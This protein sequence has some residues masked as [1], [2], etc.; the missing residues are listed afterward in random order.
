[1]SAAAS[2]GWI[3]PVADQVVWTDH[4]LAPCRR[5]PTVGDELQRR[6]GPDRLLVWSASGAHYEPPASF[7]GQLVHLRFGGMLCPP[8][9]MLQ[10]ACASIH[11]WLAADPSHVVAVHCKTGRGRSALLL[12][13]AMAHHAARG[14]APGGADRPCSPLDWLSRLAALRATDEN[15]LTLPSHRRYLFYF[16]RMLRGE[17]AGPP[18]SLRSV[19]LHAFP[20]L[21]AP[22]HITLAAHGRVLFSS[23]EAGVQALPLGCGG[24]TGGHGTGLSVPSVSS[25]LSVTY[26][27]APAR[28]R[29]GGTGGEE[30]KAGGRDGAPPPVV[31]G[32][33]VLSVTEGEQGARE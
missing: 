21:A 19:V 25:V 23:Q 15:R 9:E 12:C 22:P 28:R 10:E 26:A 32:D 18:L 30:D 2:E 5:G 24:G 33:A 20:P 27:S 17:P 4:L 7:A 11:S 6:F 31:E 16:E 3:L 8:L 14:G 1:M 29:A 13:C